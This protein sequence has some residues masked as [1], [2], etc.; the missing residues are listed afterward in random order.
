MPTPVKTTDKM[1]KHLTR[2]ER[3]LRKAAE[4]ELTR[5]KRVQ[6]RIPKW[7]GAE[8]R[9]VWL[10]TR[11]KL[12]G[13]VLLDNLDANLLAV[14]CNTVVHYQKACERMNRLDENGLSATTEEDEKAVQAWV[15]RIL[16]LSEKL[17]LSPT[18]R[19]RLAKN[20]AAKEPMDEVE[21]LLDNPDEWFKGHGA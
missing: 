12:K 10:D 20:K 11:K 14:Y 2:A 7:L 4:G 13:V 8:A 15:L 5:K 17:G 18:G 3:G 9:L 16:T 1:T 21:Q 6:L 19:A